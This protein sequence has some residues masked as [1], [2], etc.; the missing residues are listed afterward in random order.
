[1]EMTRRRLTILMPHGDG[2]VVSVHCEHTGNV[3]LFEFLGVAVDRDGVAERMF[4]PVSADL[5]DK[6]VLLIAAF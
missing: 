2:T 6:G 4:A 5:R 3:E 1:M